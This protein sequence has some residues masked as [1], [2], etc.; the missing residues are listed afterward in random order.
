MLLMLSP[1][2]RAGVS[3]G[4]GGGG[5]GTT[6]FAHDYSAGAFPNGGWGGNEANN[7][8]IARTRLAAGG[9]SGQ[10]AVRYTMSPYA[11]Q[12]VGDGNNYGGDFHY[13]NRNSG[14]FTMR[15]WGQSLFFR[16]RW[17]F[18][19]GTDFD[20]LDQNDGTPGSIWRIKNALIG[21]N[22]TVTESRIIP[23]FEGYPVAGGG[24]NWQYY[25]GVDGQILRTATQ[26]ILG[27]WVNI[28]CEFKYSS[29]NNVADGHVKI[30]INN[31][32]YASPTAQSTTTR[33]N[34]PDTDN[35]ACGYINNGIN[36]GTEL[37]FDVCDLRFATEFDSGWHS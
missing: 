13:G 5:G 24:P 18:S 28:Q 26:T 10:D 37:V 32:T 15:T 7:N 9:P 23:G 33:L 3:V 27:S 35:I 14:L 34:V 11:G 22:S 30:W 1:G 4:G 8:A 29:S 31:N 36:S 6:L 21:N 19:A 25:V 2:L 16:E 12:V 20:A 17:R